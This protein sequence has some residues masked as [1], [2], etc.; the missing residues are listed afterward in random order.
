MENFSEDI[1]QAVDV[2]R[3]GGI[4]V[5]PT[6]TIWGI[7][8]DATNSQAVKRIFE[9]KHRADSKALITLVGSI[10]ALER[11]VDEVPDIAYQLIEVTDKPLT[12]IYDKGRNVAP[13]L[14]AE[15]GSIGVRVTSEAFS[16]ALCKAFG[17]ALVSTSANISGQPSPTCFSEISDDILNAADY[18][19]TSRRD[20]ATHNTPSS[21]IKISAGGIFK[22]I[23]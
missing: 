5:Y 15:D 20:E 22:I 23:R 17:R 4:I 1:K 8:C 10:A 16:A 11:T 6:D 2:L 3:K 19:C 9:I 14:L 12:I 18:V 7:G 13:E 21:I